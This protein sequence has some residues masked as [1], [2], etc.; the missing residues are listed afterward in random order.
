V[1]LQGGRRLRVQPFPV[2]IDTLEVARQAKRSAA[3]AATQRLIRSL[4]NRAL[5]I[6][7]DRLDYSKGIPQRFEAF[8]HFL[9]QH[10][11]WR[12]RISFL[13]IAPPSREEVPEYRELRSRLERLA[14]ATNGR[15][16]EPDWMPIRYVNRSFNQ[17]TLAGFYRVS[18]I[19]VVTPLRDGMNLVAKEYIAAQDPDD[20]GV[21]ILSSFA[22]AADELKQAII[23]N[24]FDSD[25][26]AESFVTALR[27][28]LAERRER[29]QAMFDYLL[30]NDVIAWRTRYLDALTSDAARAAA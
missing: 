25:D 16:A 17:A 26:I 28:P 27:M 11:E 9:S 3:S 19:A 18:D 10:P 20:P 2:A 14:G 4:E 29:W 30:H 21:L 24:P 12:S 6:G 8:A 1:Q 22:G 13:Q 5:A 15:Y 7:V 23:I